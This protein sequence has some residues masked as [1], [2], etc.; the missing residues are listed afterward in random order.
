VHQLHVLRQ[1]AAA[2]S[3]PLT[4]PTILGELVDGLQKPS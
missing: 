3:L 2:V 1:M 4:S